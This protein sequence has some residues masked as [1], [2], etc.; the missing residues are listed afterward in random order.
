MFVRLSMWEIEPE[1]HIKTPMPPALA[2]HNGEPVRM[3]YG[4]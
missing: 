4:E 2:A 1:H 3:E